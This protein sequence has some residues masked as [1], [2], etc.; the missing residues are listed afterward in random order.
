MTPT[1]R[2]LFPRETG[3]LFDPLASAATAADLTLSTLVDARRGARMNNQ[4]FMGEK[5]PSYND[6]LT[7]LVDRLWRKTARGAQGAVQRRVQMVAVDALSGVLRQA[8]AAPQVRAEALE[9]IV[10]I[11]DLAADGLANRDVAWRAHN[12]FVV[13]RID[14]L[15]E[16]DGHFESEPVTIPPGSPI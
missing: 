6:V 12:R 5:L 3:Y 16:H 15:L 4:L 9:A 10:S 8:R 2:E 1:T 14:D 7:A 11:R 13:A